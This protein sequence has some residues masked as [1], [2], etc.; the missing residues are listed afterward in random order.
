M[1]MTDTELAEYV[2]DKF[3]NPDVV[4]RRGKDGGVMSES[5]PP[6]TLQGICFDLG[7]TASEFEGRCRVSRELARVVE[8]CYQREYDLV[9]RGG[10][11]GDLNGS[12]AGLVMKNRHE[13]REKTDNVTQVVEMGE[14]RMV[15]ALEFLRERALRV[16]KAV[17]VAAEV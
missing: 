17:D 1:E 14:D 16:G 7:L 15:A 8:L 4:V 3:R 12:F 13:W 10:L 5:L 9:F 2:M 6:P 11:S